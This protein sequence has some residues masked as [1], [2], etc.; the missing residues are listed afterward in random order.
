MFSKELLEKQKEKCPEVLVVREWIRFSAQ[1]WGFSSS[2]IPADARK[3]RQD[4]SVTARQGFGGIAA[5]GHS[6]SVC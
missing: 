5:P 4:R 1:H 2:R 3:T 6:R